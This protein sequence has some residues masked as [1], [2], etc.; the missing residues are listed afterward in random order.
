M[1]TIGK[2]ISTVVPHGQNK[3]SLSPV[4]LRHMGRHKLMLME[5]AATSKRPA[6]TKGAFGKAKTR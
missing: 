2:A 1:S 6:P 4:N 3:S 5:R